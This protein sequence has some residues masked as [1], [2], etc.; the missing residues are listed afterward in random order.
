MSVK[1]YYLEM[2]VLKEIYYKEEDMFGIYSCKPVHYNKEILNKYGNVS[3]QGTTRK[4]K[5]GETYEIKMEGAFTHSRYGDYYKIVYVNADALDTIEDQDTFLKALLPSHFESLK[6]AYP[7]SLLVNLILEDGIDVSKT[8]GIKE[9]TLASIKSKVKE[10]ADIALLMSKL[11]E[12][13]LSISM[14]DK[15]LKH[16]GTSDVALHSINQNIYN[17]C[18][19]KTFGFLTIDRIALNRGDNPTNKNRIKACIDYALKQDGNDGN[20]W[21]PKEDLLNNTEKMLDISQDYISDTLQD[22]ISNSELFDVSGKIAFPFAYKQEEEILRE[23][24]RIRDSYTPDGIS[25]AVLD[26]RIKRAEEAQGFELTEDQRFSIMDGARHGVIILNGAAGSGKTLCIKSL[27]DSLGISNVITVALSGKAVKILSNRGLNASTIHRMLGMVS[28]KNPYLPYDVI[29]VDEMSMVSASLFLEL[30]RHTSDGTKL[31]LA[32][33]SAQLPS[34]G[35]CSAD[36]LRDLLQT[37]IFPSYEL[38]KVHRQAKASGILEK[39]YEIRSGKQLFPY[40]F[41]GS[42]SFGESGDQIIASYTKEQ[43]SQIPF[44]ALQIAESYKKRVKSVE[45]LF[46]FQ[47]LVPNRKSGVLSAMSLNISMQKIFNDLSK[48][49]ISRN[50]YNFRELDKII[51]QGNSYDVLAYDS[52]NNYLDNKPSVV[53]N[54]YNGTMGY[55]HTILE[56][57]KIALIKFEDLEQLVPYSADELEKID[58]AYAITIHKAQGSGIENCLI[59]CD[60]SAYKLLSRQLIYTS[61]TRASKKCIM[62]VEG[63]A[64]YSAIQNDISSNR[65]TFLADLIISKYK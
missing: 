5:V 43:K 50:N 7:N 14:L 13:G 46:D 31:I 49:Y 1:E 36:I 51:A 30:L 19:I 3:V 64:L 6:S 58:M 25:E 26:S 32:G 62:L 17:L 45:D 33:D 10:N 9:K 53:T 41:S 35:L 44:D 16:Y 48:P 20:T 12:L 52:L 61:I 28:D 60:F 15:I 63:N 54:V 59:C 37:K 39:A 21:L 55:I 56:E 2:R 18:K 38:T 23:L 34:I 11:H 24:I 4:L 29:V 22:M 47:V 8:K 42:E 65:R 40:N 27:V 57:E